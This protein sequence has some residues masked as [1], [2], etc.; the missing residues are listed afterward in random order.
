MEWWILLVVVAQFLFAIVTLIDKY[1]VSHP[2]LPRPAVYAF[3]VSLLSS[4]ALLVLPFVSIEVPDPYV[5]GFALLSGVA[6]VISILLLYSAL[7]RADASDVVPVVG[8]AAA[9]TTFVLRFYFIDETLPANF[10]WRFLFLIIG[11]ALISHYR[12]R[13]RGLS[14]VVLSGILMGVSTMFVKVVFLNTGVGV[15]GFINGFFWT[16]MANVLAG[17]GLLLWPPTFYAVVSYE[18]KAARRG[19]RYIVANKTLAGVAFLF[20]LVAI[21]LG[22]VSLVNALAGIQYVFLLVL[23]FLLSK[24]LP[25][26]FRDA[27]TS[28]GL[29]QKGVAIA[30]IVTGFFVLFL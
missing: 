30:I 21:N 19:A 9:I 16:R 24:R 18:R 10:A 1:L 15:D 23:A 2:T 29:A 13:W 7:Q 4:V 27:Q 26:F 3:Y 14:M 25:Q 28:Y 20:V 11:T 17:L 6:Y 12:F 22:D 5:A 8:V